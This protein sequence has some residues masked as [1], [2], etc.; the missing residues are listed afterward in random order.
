MTGSRMQQACSPGAQAARE[1]RKLKVAHGRPAG[2][3]TKHGRARRAQQCARRAVTGDS[4]WGQVGVEADQTHTQGHVGASTAPR[5]PLVT[6]RVERSS[7]HDN[8]RPGEG[9]QSGVGDNTGGATSRDWSGVS[10]GDVGGEAEKPSGEGDGEQKRQTK[11]TG[12]SANSTLVL[13]AGRLP[14]QDDW[15]SLKRQAQKDRRTQQTRGFGHWNAERTA[16]ETL[17]VPPI[18]HVEQTWR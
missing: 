4:R 10:D 6:A 3:G 15:K 7:G 2:E 5:N 11:L 17:K 14:T 12:R 1:L 13:R 9:A 18:Q 16:R 8:E